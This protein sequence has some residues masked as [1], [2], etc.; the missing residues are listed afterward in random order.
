MR[1]LCLIL[2][3]FIVEE[4]DT[5]CFL[6]I[7]YGFS[8]DLVIIVMLNTH[9]HKQMYNKGASTTWVHSPISGTRGPGAIPKLWANTKKLKSGL[10]LAGALIM[11]PILLWALE[12]S[13]DCA[14]PSGIVLMKPGPMLHDGKKTSTC[15]NFLVKRQKKKYIYIY[16]FH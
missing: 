13:L 6:Y 14:I 4:S 7:D 15:H 3:I 5:V 16:F 8:P 9:A 11:P 1:F 10:A 12:V 2:F